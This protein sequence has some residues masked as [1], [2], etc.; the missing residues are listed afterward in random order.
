TVVTDTSTDGLDPDG[1]DN[2][3]N[4]DESDPTPVV[5]CPMTITGMGT[6]PTC[7]AGTDGS[8]NIDVTGGTADYAYNW[9]NGLTTGSASGISGEPFDITGLSA[10][11]YSVTVFDAFGCSDVEMI[12]L[13]D[14]APLSCNITG[15]LSVCDGSTGN[16]YDGPAGMST[17]SWNISG[18]GTIN[19]AT[20]GQSVTVDA[21]AAGSFTLTLSIEDGIGCTANCNQMITVDPN[22][23]CN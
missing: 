9:D 6:D 22:P 17:Y 12:T 23:V 4:P 1:M 8:V 18:N 7:N 19:G 13:N 11:T 10:G 16:V 2:D 15:D 3:D 5:F 14:P 20:N 21:G